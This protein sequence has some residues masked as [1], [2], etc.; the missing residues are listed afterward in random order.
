MI[1][2]VGD[3]LKAKGAGIIL[4]RSGRRNTHFYLT[5][6]HSNNYFSLCFC[7]NSNLGSVGIDDMIKHLCHSKILLL[8]K[9]TV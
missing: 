1:Y 5:Y 8:E 2:K 6:P 3:T 9:R 4:N 7:D